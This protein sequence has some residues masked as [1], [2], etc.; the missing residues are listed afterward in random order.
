[1]PNEF[2]SK[3]QELGYNIPNAK[4]KDSTSKINLLS[5]ITKAL[6]FIT[7]ANLFYC[8]YTKC[9]DNISQEAFQDGIT[10]NYQRFCDAIKDILLDICKLKG[11]KLTSESLAEVLRK[12]DD[13]LHLSKDQKEALTYIQIRNNIVHGY[14][15][16]E[17]P[18]YDNN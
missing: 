17:L 18:Y 4:R 6:E 13:F 1:M 2:T 8:N 9:N 14:F 15:N 16:A 11:I 12:S 3:L 5:K 10:L 7:K